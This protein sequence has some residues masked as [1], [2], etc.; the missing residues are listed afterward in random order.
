MKTWLLSIIIRQQKNQK[1]MKA[2][3]TKNMYTEGEVP[4]FRQIAVLF[5]HQSNNSHVNKFTTLTTA[6]HSKVSW[7]FSRSNFVCVWGFFHQALTSNSSLG[8]QCSKCFSRQKAINGVKR[9]GVKPQFLYNKSLS[10]VIDGSIHKLTN[11]SVSLSV[12]R[13]TNGV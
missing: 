1:K 5:V 13:V 2:S 12:C 8:Q 9:T 11:V 3:K 4:H 6:F 7:L 10:N